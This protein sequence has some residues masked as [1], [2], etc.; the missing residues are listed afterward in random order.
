[1]ASG[2]T[3]TFH[4]ETGVVLPAVPYAPP[5]STS[6]RSSVGSIGSRSTATARFVMGPSVRSVSS[7]GCAVA[8]SM[9][10]SAAWRPDSPRTG[11]GSTASPS[12]WPPWV[13]GVV[14]SGRRSGTS[15][16]RA[17]R[18]VAP[19]R[20]LQHRPGVD[21]DLLGVHVPGHARDGPDVRVGRGAREEQRERVVDAGVAVDEQGHGAGHPAT[22]AEGRADGPRL[23]HEQPALEPH[24]AARDH[25]H[26][27]RWPA[28]PDA[29]IC[30]ARH[31]LRHPGPRPRSGVPRIRGRRPRR[32]GRLR[33][34]RGGPPAGA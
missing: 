25:R 22:V 14:T 24:P 6:R 23:G 7:P 30:R 13:S 3:A 21:R 32:G 1:M 31:G 20:Q 18:H 9:M 34:P 19:A 12:P 16:P 2:S 26:P 4:S 5:M 11:G 8:S 15:R 27:G 29:G 17:D 10:R 33:R 28:G